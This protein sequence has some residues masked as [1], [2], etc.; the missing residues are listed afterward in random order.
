[1]PIQAVAADNSV[2]NF[3]DGT[4][5]AVVD[6]VMK[7]YA[8]QAVAP[9]GE[10]PTL[11]DRAV[12]SPIGR[13]IHDIVGGTLHGAADTAALIPMLSGL[14]PAADNLASMV[15]KPYDAAIARNQNTPGYAAARSEANAIQQRR[16]GS[17]FEDQMLAPMLPTLAGATGLAGG[18]DMSNAMADAQTQGQS[19]YATQHPWL[20]RGAGL[21]G[22]LLM[23]PEM[24]KLPALPEKQAVPSISDLKTAAGD[25]YKRVDNSGLTVSGP[26]FDSM[27]TDLQSKLAK[28]GFDPDLHPDATAAFNRLDK[29]RSKEAG[30]QGA[31]APQ[32]VSFNDVNTLREIAGD[33]A[34]AQLPRDAMRGNMIQN[35]IDDFVDNLTPEHMSGAGADPTAAVADLNQARDLYSRMKQAETIQGVLDKAEIKSAGYSQ[36]GDENAIRAGFRQLALNDRKM[37][38]LTPDVQQAVK[39]VAMGGP[40][41]NTLRNIGKF[42]PHGP[43]AAASGAAL[44][45][46]AGAMLGGLTGAVG[47][48]SV[49]AALLPLVGEAARAGATSR[50]MA[51]AQ[52]AL[53]TAALG[54]SGA[55]PA[56][57]PPLQAPRLPT[58]G[59]LPY[60]PLLLQPQRQSV[61]GR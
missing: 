38:R 34:G 49:G 58:N 24:G 61:S 14:K 12:A 27:V 55:P 3:P 5:D 18:L 48:S 30:G 10:Q 2:H 50:T 32:D 29:L 15:N 26:A 4:P 41:T 9:K 17:G 39:D 35:H 19:T 46:G 16:G 33:A 54:R 42:A 52:R 21:M 25:A 44:G 57:Q 28:K 22:G 37:A 6:K 23:A 56:L 11:M 31:E 53:D 1:M 59:V 43:V 20:A 36:S 47:G 8:V 13:G 7:D 45:S 60:G 40:L 51:A